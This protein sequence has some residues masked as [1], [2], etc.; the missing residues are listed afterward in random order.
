MNA[1]LKELCKLADI[2][3]LVRKTFYKGNERRDVTSPKY[4]LVSAHT[5]RRS[6]ICNALAK[7]ISV[8]VVMQWTGHAD[9]KS[10]KP[11]VDVADSIRVQEMQKFNTDDIR[12]KF[13]LG[14]A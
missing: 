4:E 1:E 5:G 8:N 9:Y 11:Y 6:F 14:A 7:G 13:F 2:S 10:M 12:I 3:E